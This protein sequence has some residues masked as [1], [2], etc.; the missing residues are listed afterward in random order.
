MVPNLL[1]AGQ[2]KKHVDVPMP[3]IIHL[4][5]RCMGGVNLFDQFVANY[6]SKNNGGRFFLGQ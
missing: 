4:Y 6:R 2:K 3:K 5:N 1:H